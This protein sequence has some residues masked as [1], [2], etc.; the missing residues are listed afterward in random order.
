VGHE[1]DIY[2]SDGCAIEVK[3]DAVYLG[4]LLTT[5]GGEHAEVTRRLGEAT[6][7]FNKLA[8]VWSHAGIFKHRKVQ[9]FC[10]C[11]LTKLLFSLETAAV[12]TTTA[13]RLDAFQARCLRRILKIPP[14]YVSRVSNE[15]VRLRARTEQVSQ[16]LRRRQQLFYVTLVLKADADPVRQRILMPGSVVPRQVAFR[17]RRGRPRL[18]WTAQAFQGALATAGSK[19]KLEQILFACNRRRAVAK[20]RQ[21]LKL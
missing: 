21:L 9:I 18:S 1:R 13:A 20:W 8:A 7:S 2:A 12:T 11:V 10:A 3:R 14:A 17:R 15:E 6:G 4:A 16:L 19:E 5:T